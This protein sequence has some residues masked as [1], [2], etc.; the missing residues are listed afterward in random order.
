MK[1]FRMY[2]KIIGDNYS[3]VS[4]VSAH[5]A[6]KGTS[7]LPFQVNFSRMFVRWTILEERDRVCR[8][9]AC[10]LSSTVEVRSPRSKDQARLLTVH[11]KN[12]RFPKLRVPQLWCKSIVCAVST[13]APAV[14]E[15][16]RNWETRKIGASML[17]RTMLF[18]PWV[19]K[20]FCLCCKHQNSWNRD[21]PNC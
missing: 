18:V 17:I 15:R 4:R 1:F 20:S 7:V 6:S 12:F 13:W 16:Q 21:R 3:W 11:Y 10:L 2:Q 14:A 5:L 19:T 9:Q 8:G